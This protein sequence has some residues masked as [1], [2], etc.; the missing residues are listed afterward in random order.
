MN[1][2]QRGS[3]DQTNVVESDITKGKK[4]SLKN[5]IGKDIKKKELEGRISDITLQYENKK[6][7]CLELINKRLRAQIDN[8]QA[9]MAN[10]KEGKKIHYFY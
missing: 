9:Q 7:E 2:G 5:D 8:L 10:K 3:K 4:P 1:I 6:K